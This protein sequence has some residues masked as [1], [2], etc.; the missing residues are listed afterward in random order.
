MAYIKIAIPKLREI[1]PLLIKYFAFK[2]EMIGEE[3]SNACNF[4]YK[5]QDS[6]PNKEQYMK[7]S[8]MLNAFLNEFAVDDGLFDWKRYAPRK[9]GNSKEFDYISYMMNSEHDLPLFEVEDGFREKIYILIAS[10]VT[11]IKDLTDTTEFDDSYTEIICKISDILLIV[12]FLYYKYKEGQLHTDITWSE[13]TMPYLTKVRPEMLKLYEFLQ[14]T[15]PEGSIG[16]NIN[17]KFTMIP[18]ATFPNAIT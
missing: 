15:I 18:K 6:I 1:E 8:P 3:L 5:S 4:Y 14:S 16:K 7:D 10:Y 11:S 2:R 17:G 9:A 13:N 12:T